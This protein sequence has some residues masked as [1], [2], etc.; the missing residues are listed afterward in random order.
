MK[1]DPG[2]MA[3]QYPFIAAQASSIK[4]GTLNPSFAA[5]SRNHREYRRGEFTGTEKT[6]SL[7]SVPLWDMWLRSALRKSDP[8]FI[9]SVVSPP[10]GEPGPRSPQEYNGATSAPLLLYSCLPDRSRALFI[11][12][13]FSGVVSGPG[14]APLAHLTI[15]TTGQ[16][17]LAP[18]ENDDACHFSIV[19]WNGL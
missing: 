14:E 15:K 3:R 11:V 9:Y 1:S 12:Q 7:A 17:R 2:D 6:T 18:W 13:D 5:T 19:G 10:P 16:Y 8:A 4:N